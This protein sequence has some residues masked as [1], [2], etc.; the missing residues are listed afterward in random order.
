M[1]AK[2]LVPGNYA[3]S[4]PVA[5]S[6]TSGHWLSA[7]ANFSDFQVQKQNVIASPTTEQSQPGQTSLKTA[8]GNSAAVSD[9]NCVTTVENH[10]PLMQ[11]SARVLHPPRAQAMDSKLFNGLKYATLDQFLIESPTIYDLISGT[12]QWEICAADEARCIKF[13]RD[14]CPTKRVFIIT[15]GSQ[16]KTL[17]PHIHDLPQVYAIYIHCSNVEYHREW[18]TQ[19]PKIRIICDDDK[20][21]L[22]QLAVDVAQANLEWGEALLEQGK[23][24]LAKKKFTKALKNLTDYTSGQH[25]PAFEK[26]ILKRLEECE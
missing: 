26:E 8:T 25:D 18:S 12:Y 10:L 6:T 20:Y 5:S 23:K 17:I 14:D 4:E 24:D 7:F 11:K 9:G 15:S 3:K 22:P 21:L 1:T 16:G 2:S 19:F 13:I